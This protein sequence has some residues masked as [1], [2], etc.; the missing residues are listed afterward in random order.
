MVLSQNKCDILLLVFWKTFVVM[1]AL[2]FIVMGIYGPYIGI[3]ML[4]SGAE[5]LLPGIMILILGG[6]AFIAVSHEFLD[7]RFRIDKY[8]INGD[9]SRED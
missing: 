7:H 4:V 2:V 8:F 5:N 9:N 3:S 6:S 1:W